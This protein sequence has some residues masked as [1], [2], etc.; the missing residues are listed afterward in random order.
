MNSMFRLLFLFLALLF[1]GNCSTVAP[2]PQ[3]A[4]TNSQKK[5]TICLNMIVKDESHVIKRCLDSVKP[6]IDYWVIMDTGSKD[7]TQK[8]IKEYMKDI[9]GQLHERPWKNWGETRTEALQFAKGKADYIL[10]MDA[11]DILEYE[12]AALPE[13]TED[14]YCLWRGDQ[15]FSY[16]NPQLAKDGKP[17]KWIGVTH[18]YLG[19]DEPHSWG[20][21]ESIR[22]TSLNDGATRLHDPEKYRKNVALLEEGLKK[23]PNN[24]RYVFYLAE[25]YHDAGER[26]KALE[27][28]QKRVKLGGWEEEVFWSKLRIGHILKELGLPDNLVLEA[29]KDAMSYRPHR[30]EPYYYIAEIFNNRREY[31]AAYAYLRA[32]E[33]AAKPQAKDVLFNVDWIPEYGLLFQLSICSYYVGHY[34]EALEACDQLLA[35]TNLPEGWRTL[36]KAN[37]EFPLQKL[38]EVTDPVP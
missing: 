4:K 18:E 34:E 10:F 27:W 9:P 25:S 33:F 32:Y 35:K 37:R 26:A 15:N 3:P 17:W 2:A 11:D 30:A 24:I 14:L 36:A 38:Q 19:C 12:E 23:E 1:V 13:L 28:Y 31:S 21:L 16:L 6:L 20:L 29:Y 8:I 7:G 5:Q 22:Y